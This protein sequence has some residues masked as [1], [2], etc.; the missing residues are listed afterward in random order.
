MAAG[1]KVF[2]DRGCEYCHRIAGHGG[3][4][5]PDLTD[6]GDRLTKDQMKTRLFSGAANMPS[7]VTKLRGAELEDLLTFLA[8]RERGAAPL[9]SP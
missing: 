2:Y 1:A 7:Y 3:V 9:S 6:V 8:S 5:G 4:R